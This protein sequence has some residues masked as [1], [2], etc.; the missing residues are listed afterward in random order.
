MLIRCPTAPTALSNGPTIIEA[1]CDF[2]ASVIDASI[3]QNIKSIQPTAT[4]QVEWQALI[5]AMNEHTLFPVRGLSPSTHTSGAPFF[6]HCCRS[7]FSKRG[8]FP[9]TSP[10]DRGDG[11]EKNF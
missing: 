8:R 10:P 6:L 11:K 9:F 5:D 4:A 3:K 7:S 1:Q 2:I